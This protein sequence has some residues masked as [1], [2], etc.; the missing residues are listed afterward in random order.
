M[1]SIKGKFFTKILVYFLLLLAC[2]MITQL[3]NFP[4]KEYQVKNK[5]SP[6]SLKPSPQVWAHARNSI[7]SFERAVFD[8]AKG[9]EFDSHYDSS[10]FKFVISHDLP[11]QTHKGK[12]FFLE[13]VFEKVPFT[14]YYWLDLKNLS[15]E[16]L[17]DVA[18]RLKYLLKKYQKEKYLF[19]ESWQKNEISELSKS[20]IQTIYWISLK[21]PPGSFD[22]LQELHRTRELIVNSNFYAISGPYKVFK[23]YKPDLFDR[24]PLFVF[25]VNNKKMLEDFKSNSRVKVI[26]TDKP[27]FFN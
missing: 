25:T 9:I 10:L 23:R 7:L 1:I 17:E 3:V 4:L 24:F 18:K 27:S 6:L 26:L 11:Y 14:G 22:H 20:S 8:G 21:H 5:I 13:E 15:E 16:N 12:L 2:I 19:V